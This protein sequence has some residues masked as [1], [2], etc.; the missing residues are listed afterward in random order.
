MVLAFNLSAMFDPLR[1]EAPESFRTD[2]PW[3]EYMLWGY[4][5]HAR[6]GAYIEPRRHCRRS[7]SRCW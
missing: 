7:S 2:R 1:I 6:F 4:G 5:M 3:E